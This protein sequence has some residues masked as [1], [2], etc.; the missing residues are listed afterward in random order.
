M[1]KK[2]TKII[3][4]FG[5][6]V[7]GLFLILAADFTCGTSL[8]AQ[9]AQAPSIA[10]PHA[11]G[12]ATVQLPPPEV[13]VIMI[14]SSIIALSQANVTNN[15]TVLNALGSRNFQANNSPQ[16]LAVTFKSFRDNHI[17]LSP[18]TYLN[19]Q[20]TAQPTITNGR[21]R[22]IGMFASKPMQVNFDLTFEPETGVWKLFGL[23][24]NLSAAPQ[25]TTNKRK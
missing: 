12:P 10:G 3:R 19:P 11:Q 24:V 14:R 1:P 18:V 4:I 20:L 2:Q 22:L 8:Y 21:L 23:G 13:M 9:P 6:V 17:D 7:F 15:Y 16:Q 5:N 25:T